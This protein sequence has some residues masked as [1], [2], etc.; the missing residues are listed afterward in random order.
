MSD[1]LLV[2]FVVCFFAMFVALAYPKIAFTSS[3][4]KAFGIYFFAWILTIIGWSVVNTEFEDGLVA[5]EN[6]SWEEADNS[7][8]LVPPWDENYD[9]AQVLLERIE[10][11]RNPVDVALEDQAVPDQEG[12]AEAQRL[13]AVRTDSIRNEAYLV[14]ESLEGLLA[15]GEAMSPLRTGSRLAECGR[16]MRA[17]Q[18]EVQS[19]R[20]RIMNLPPHVAAALVEASGSLTLC[21]SCSGDVA[22]RMCAAAREEL[23]TA[24]RA[25]DSL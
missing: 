24:R 12:V 14:I 22:P 1:F 9:S 6:K 10:L 23:G 4:G 17:K 16:T 5:Y 2:L 8:S 3:R 13:A 7:L 11:E 18:A 15:D 25:I 20:D 19:Y 21:A